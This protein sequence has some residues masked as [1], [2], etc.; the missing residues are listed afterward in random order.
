MRRR[1]ARRMATRKGGTTVAVSNEVGSGVV[2]LG[3]D[4]RRWRDLLGSVNACWVAA[5]DRAGLVVAGR[6]LPLV[7]AEGWLGGTYGITDDD[8]F[9]GVVRFESRE[10]VGELER[11]RRSAGRAFR[12][13]R[14][15]SNGPRGGSPDETG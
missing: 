6:V 3:A 9:V 13:G 4:V 10:H 5:S 8:E 14:K 12:P 2:P 1:Y 15:G 11:N 7:P